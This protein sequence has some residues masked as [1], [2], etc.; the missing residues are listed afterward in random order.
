MRRFATWVLLGPAAL[1]LLGACGKV[2]LH[3]SDL[4]SR[5]VTDVTSH[6]ARPD[7]PVADAA[8]D[9]PG[10]D[11]DTGVDGPAADLPAID[12]PSPTCT[13]GNRNG[14]ETDVDCGGT[15]PACADGKTCKAGTDCASGI[16]QSTSPG[17]ATCAAIY[18]K[19]VAI[20]AGTFMMGSPTNEPCR[21]PDETQHQVTLTNSFEIM[22]TEVT[23]GQFQALMGYNPSK[24]T[25]CGSDCPVDWVSWYEAAAYCNALSTARGLPQCYACTGSGSAVSCS[26]VT[27]Y[28]G[29]KVY[30]CP[31][32]RLATEAEWEYSYRAGT[33]TALHSGPITVCTG[34]DPNA[35]KIAWYKQNAGGTP[36]PVAQKSPNAWSLHDMSG[37]AWEWCH[38][39]LQ[40]DLGPSPVTD[41]W[42][43]PS[44][45]GRIARGG[46]WMHNPQYLRAGL[47]GGHNIPTARESY[48]AFRCVRTL[49]AGIVAHWKLDEGQGTTA[50]DS[51]KNSNHGTINGGAA[52]TTGVVGSGALQ[53][54]GTDDWVSLGADSSLKPAKDLSVAAWFKTSSVGGVIVRYR[55]LGWHLWQYPPGGLQAGIYAGT[56]SAPKAC[57]PISPA[58]YNDN[59]WHLAAVTVDHDGTGSKVDLYVD[60]VLVK[61]DY[62]TFE[63]LYEPGYA[64]I[65]RD[66]N[67]S[68]SYF[69]GAIDDVRLYDRALSKSEIVDLY[70]LG[71]P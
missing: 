64:A 60:G 59:K 7:A 63:V 67:V 35:D 32:Y 65:G 45:T 56:A 61:S 40:T 39:W 3:P 27:S 70:K 16:C 53:F 46:S 29:A 1:L 13:D 21:Y 58:T 62:C 34:V 30:E 55:M 41:P 43:A 28:A 2:R 10:P 25:A 6:D 50:A 66:G 69:K 38:D 22:A 17:A 42:G 47:R 11:A 23:Q 20:P 12:G 9:G 26:E 5:D 37:N 44:G 24:K 71:T 48:L 8:L 68:A 15:C 51:S 52:W 19:W 18:T 57:Y 14:T 54:D 49:D 36:H 4:D 31:G 33:T